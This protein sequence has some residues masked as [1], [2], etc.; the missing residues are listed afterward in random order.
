MICCMCGEYYDSGIEDIIHMCKKCK[1][2]ID[3]DVTT[4]ANKEEIKA[5]Q[6]LI[7]IEDLIV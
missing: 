3:S 2:T 5:I 6:D 4:V 1:F 7:H